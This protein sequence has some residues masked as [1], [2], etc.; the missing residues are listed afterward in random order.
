MLRRIRNTI[1]IFVLTLIIG[2]L[3][4]Y[5]QDIDVKFNNKNI[6][7]VFAD[8]KIADSLKSTILFYNSETF[9]IK[10]DE[11]SIDKIEYLGPVDSINESEAIELSDDNVKELVNCFDYIS[12]KDMDNKI[13]YEDP[14]CNISFYSGDFDKIESEEFLRLLQIRN[15][16]LKQALVSCLLNEVSVNLDNLTVSNTV[17]NILNEE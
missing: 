14:V 17:L 13:N 9:M 5:A 7:K 16:N 12:I 4:V 1:F 11:R 3:S 6:E 15:T 8:D 2:T 10:Y